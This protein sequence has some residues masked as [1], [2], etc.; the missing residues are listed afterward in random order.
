MQV[1]E[2]DDAQRLGQPGFGRG[3]FQAGGMNPKGFDDEA[4]QA[5][6]QQAQVEG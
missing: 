3:D 1:A 6:C 5:Y 4:V 2:L